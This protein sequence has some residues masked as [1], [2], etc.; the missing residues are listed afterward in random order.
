MFLALLYVALP[1]LAFIALMRILA[2]LFQ[3]LADRHSENE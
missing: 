3:H 1:I 2:K